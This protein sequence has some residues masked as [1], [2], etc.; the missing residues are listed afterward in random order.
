MVSDG[1]MTVR[2]I[3]RKFIVWYAVYTL[4]LGWFGVCFFI[5]DVDPCLGSELGYWILGCGALP[6]LVLLVLGLLRPRVA[7]GMA[8]FCGALVALAALTFTIMLHSNM[9]LLLIIPLSGFVVGAIVIA[10]RWRR[11]FASPSMNR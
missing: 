5:R 3:D 4:I 8:V 10:C 1:Q 2:L 11:V 7:Y 6:S 9:W